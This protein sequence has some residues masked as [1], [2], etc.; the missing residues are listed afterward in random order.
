MISLH[1]NP[2]PTSAQTANE[3]AT[4]PNTAAMLN[5]H[6]VI[7]SLL[8]FDSAQNNNTVEEAAAPTETGIAD[9][10]SA[11]APTAAAIIPPS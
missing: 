4:N 2:N 1:Q 6:D 5:L 10:M 3:G 11:L 9:V 8:P 7:G